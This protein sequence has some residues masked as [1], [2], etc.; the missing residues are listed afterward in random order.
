[1]LNMNGFMKYIPGR[2]TF[3]QCVSTFERLCG[4]CTLLLKKLEQ[5]KPVHLLIEHKKHVS[6][7]LYVMW[8]IGCCFWIYDLIFMDV[9]PGADMGMSINDSR[10]ALAI[11][12][13][14]TIGSVFVSFF[15]FFIIKLTYNLFHDGVESFFS[16]KWHSLV[17]PV[18]YLVI[19][20]CAHSFTGAIKLAGMTA[21]NQVAGLIH[22]SRQNTLVIQKEAPADL[23]HKLNNLL[24]MIE[25][26]ED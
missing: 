18:S 20:Y 2:E 5:L 10:D 3:L 19:L 9:S 6:M 26:G 23:E 4:E 8:I 16:V 14:G 1:M 24:K 7:F 17:K 25:K 13:F 21:Y 12:F 15:A 22:T 11:L